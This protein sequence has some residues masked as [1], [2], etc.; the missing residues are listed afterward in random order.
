MSYPGTG[1]AAIARR[2]AEHGGCEL[3]VGLEQPDSVG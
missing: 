3:Q 2:L 1:R